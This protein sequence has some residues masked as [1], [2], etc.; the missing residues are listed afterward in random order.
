MNPRSRLAGYLLLS[1]PPAVAASAQ[2][3][4]SITAVG[5]GVNV[6]TATG[7]DVLDL[8]ESAI[9]TFG[10]FGS[11]SG[12]TVES[13]LDYAG[14]PDVAVITV[15]AAGTAATLEFPIIGFST[16]FVGF[17]ADDLADQIEDFIE[18]DGND[19][20][21]DVLEAIRAESVAAVLDGN[22]FATTAILARHTFGLYGT[23]S[24]GPSWSRPGRSTTTPDEAG[25]TYVNSGGAY[26]DGPFIDPLAPPEPTRLWFE[27]NPRAGAIQADI[28][29][30]FTTGVDVAGGFFFNETIGVAAGTSFQFVELEGTDVFHSVGHVA[31]PIRVVPETL[32]EAGNSFALQF[33]PFVTS[34]V[35]GSLDAA[36]G[37]A[38]FGV[39]G[40]TN[41]RVGLGGRAAVDWGSQIVYFEGED[42]FLDDFEFET[43]LSQTLVT[44]G[45]LGTVFLDDNGRLFIDGGATYSVF[46]ENAG[47]DEWVAPEA[48][49]GW[50]TG[51]ASR[52][53]LSWQG[54]YGT[55]DY[56]A[57]LGRAS[58]VYA[59]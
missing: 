45:V 52:I 33:T 50:R 30:G 59:F 28:F 34:G 25:L 35:G 8:A 41:V 31:V 13:T 16:A 58:F 47:V 44:T 48:G 32:D 54:I 53:R 51:R 1:C 26:D 2:D 29:D 39:G 55:G 37:G 40:A 21:A 56:E 19:V 36:A 23:G 4:F 22:P 14:V 10:A 11:L 57:H 49:L 18:E 43:E 20:Y 24:L 42:L 3:L 9:E 17:D 15:N 7:S 12:Q 38:F 6:V 27:V 46:L 5:D